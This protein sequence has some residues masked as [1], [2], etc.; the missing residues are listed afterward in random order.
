LPLK[1][2]REGGQSGGTAAAFDFL[3][4][5]SEMARRVREVDWPATPLGPPDQH[6]VKP[7]DFEILKRILG[8]EG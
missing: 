3:P 8:S 1:E 5:D 6:L 2:R 4:D 7:V